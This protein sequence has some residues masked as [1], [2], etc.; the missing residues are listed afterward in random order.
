MLKNHGCVTQIHVDEQTQ[1]AMAVL[2]KKFPNASS[3]L[4]SD[5]FVP[6]WFVVKC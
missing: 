4:Q 3:S 6:V 5:N 1:D 2:Q